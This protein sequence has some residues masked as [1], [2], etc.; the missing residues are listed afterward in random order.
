MDLGWSG[1]FECSEVLK[2][3][4]VI[5]QWTSCTNKT[6]LVPHPQPL[7]PR[8]S[9]FPAGARSAEIS[10]GGGVG[11]NYVLNPT[12]ESQATFLEK[13]GYGMARTFAGPI[14]SCRVSIGDDGDQNEANPS[15]RYLIGFCGLVR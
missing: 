12:L 3:R 1:D 13:R 10:E 8:G 14:L 7:S 2:F 5:M 15:P 9:F 11:P 6:A 4:M